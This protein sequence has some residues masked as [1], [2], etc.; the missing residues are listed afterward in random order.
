MKINSLLIKNFKT[1]RELNIDD[2]DNAMI[3]VGKN[4]TGKT[5]ILHAIRAV[6]GKYEV[7]STDFHNPERNIEIAVELGISSD[8]IRV[9]YKSGVLSIYK[10]FSMWYDEFCLKLPSFTKGRDEYELVSNEEG[11]AQPENKDTVKGEVYI[12]SD[13]SDNADMVPKGQLYMP[14]EFT[15]LVGSQPH[16]QITDTDLGG[17]LR[18]VFVV[19]PDLNIRY[20]DGVNRNNSNIKKVIPNCHFIDASRNI[21]DIQNDIFFSETDDALIP[22][23][24]NYCFED[25]A[26]PCMDCFR[27]I[28]GILKKQ[29]EE[30][31]VVET[32][33]LLEYKLMQ[34]KLDSFMEKL[35]LYYTRNSG[36]QQ[37]IKFVMN[38]NTD[39]LLRLDT[40]VLNRDRYSADSVETMSAGAKSIYIFSLLQTYIEESNSIP[41]LIM[42]EDPEI[43]LHPQLQ[44][45]AS[46]IL[47]KLSSK[48]QVFFSTHSPNMIFNFNSK[49]IKQVVL[50]EEG[51]T[52]LNENS[53]IDTIL[54]DLGYSANDLMNVNFVFIVE[55]KQ[56]SNRLPLLLN[57]YYSEIYNDDGTL[58]RVSIITTNSCT[59]IK[60]Y[61]NLK[62]IN[63]LYLKDQFLMIRDSDGK[64]PQA[65]VKQLCN[66]YFSR[67]QED[68]GNLP[69][70][71][72][73]N[74]LVLKYYSFE[75][76]FLNPEVMVK[77]GVLR[78]EEEFYNTLLDKFKSYLHK[79]ASVKRMKEATGLIIRTK[80]DIK[81]NMET[82]KIYV[83]G[84]NLFDIFY[85]KYKGEKETEILKAYIDAAPRSDFADILNAIDNFIYFMNR[86]RD[87][88]ED[89]AEIGQEQV[90]TK[91]KKKKRHKG[92]NRQV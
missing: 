19:D 22:I 30:L 90:Y 55:G 28:P 24:D 34:I 39:N 86:R 54:D 10:T 61:A 64:D 51:N 72:P 6:A 74:V 35:N 75:N 7:K 31:S 36:R 91:H 16:A 14:S 42:I 57:K 40:A 88:E 71:Q 2:I 45:V 25:P 49:Q 5:T 73:R 92:K 48:N 58:Q 12:R 56:D 9:F 26:K 89:N 17:I 78:H 66:Y 41:S 62:Y 3:V 85:G 27:C 20:S 69:R 52:S 59:N 29:P 83:R 68:K 43:Y 38:L 82:I 77:I 70:I 60:T 32:V 63:K 46:E 11:E 18:F 50:D 84:H 8:D 15:G 1:I 37:N 44:K 13:L 67:S 33:R 23:R 79:I 76:Y 4:S 81:R 47:Y 53:D 65:L 21:K 87:D 80:E